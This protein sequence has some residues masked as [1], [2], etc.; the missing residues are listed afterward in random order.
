MSKAEYETVILKRRDIIR[1]FAQYLQNRCDNALDEEEDIDGSISGSRASSPRVRHRSI[2]NKKKKQKHIVVHDGE[3]ED[4]GESDSGDD[5]VY[6]FKHRRGAIRTRSKNEIESE[7][8]TDAGRVSVSMRKRNSSMTWNADDELEARRQS[9]LVNKLT[10]KRK[11]SL[12]VKAGSRKRKLTH[13]KTLS[14]LTSSSPP[15]ILFYKLIN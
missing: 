14:S 8:T 3:E 2:V 9:Q 15:L 12:V 6:E 5:V 10:E 13:S 1:S 7:S 11:Q 4:T